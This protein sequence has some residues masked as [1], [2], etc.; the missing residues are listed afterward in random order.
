MLIIVGL[1][2]PT[3]EYEKTFHNMG[4][5]AVE[6]IAAALGKKIKRAECSSLT[7]SFSLKGEK[8]V[9]AKPLTYMNLS[10]L[11]VKGL[12][13]KYKASPDDL[14]VIYDDFD[15][16][17]FSLRARASGSAG[18]HNGMKSIIGEIGAQEFKRI[19]IGIGSTDIGKRDYV[20]SDIDREDRENFEKVF[21]K[22]VEAIKNYIADR[23]FDLLMRTLN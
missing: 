16:D 5:M 22:I 8:I 20:L 10:G 9:L 2:N 3:P 21:E 7:A 6:R 14:I 12:L 1:G 4:Y 23:D 17:R 13:K 19:R 18:T 11:A 15:I